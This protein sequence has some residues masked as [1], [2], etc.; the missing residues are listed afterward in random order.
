VV[1]NLHREKTVKYL[2][3]SMIPYDIKPMISQTKNKQSKLS[4]LPLALV[5]FAREVRSYTYDAH[6]II[7]DKWSLHQLNVP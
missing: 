7:E 6:C 5:F 2:S 3:I 4:I 1:L